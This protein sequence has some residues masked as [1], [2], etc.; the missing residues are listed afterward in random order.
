MLYYLEERELQNERD[1]PFPLSLF[2]RI[3]RMTFI[4]F[5]LLRLLPSHKYNAARL[6]IMNGSGRMD[7]VD[8]I[9]ALLL[10]HTFY[11][12]CL[13]LFQNSLK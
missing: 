13:D 5:I 1:I 7:G 8:L 6:R 12:I 11:W 9:V 3:T 4:I 10:E 2:E